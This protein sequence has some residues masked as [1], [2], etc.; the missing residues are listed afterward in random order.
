MKSL[1]LLFFGWLCLFNV[2][3]SA[4]SK[5]FEIRTA[6]IALIARWYTLDASYRPN[7]Q[8]ALGPS[9][10]IYNHDGPGGILSPAYQGKSFGA[11]INYYFQSI[12]VNS[13]YLGSHFLYDDYRSFPHGSSG[14]RDHIG[15]SLQ[16][17]AGYF[18]RYQSLTFHT[19]LGFEQEMGSYEDVAYNSLT[20]DYEMT[21]GNDTFFKLL[22][23]FKL[24][25]EF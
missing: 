2:S 11:H 4:E 20:S 9:I 23:E 16:A 8:W 15:T 7:P 3:A 21:T 10:V 14:Y 5:Q 17:V 1:G 6:P 19:G 25:Y 24:G 18:G 13:F 12:D 22:I